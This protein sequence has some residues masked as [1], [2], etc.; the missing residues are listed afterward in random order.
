MTNVHQ[1]GRVALITGASRGIG[2]AVARLLASRGMRVAVN[3]R[4]SRDEAD[5]VVTSIRSAGGLAMAVQ[6][7]VRDESAVLGMVDQV[8]AALGEVRSWS[9]TR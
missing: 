7:D 8:R 6:A 9:T 1:D 2:A 5:D 3:Y 4:S